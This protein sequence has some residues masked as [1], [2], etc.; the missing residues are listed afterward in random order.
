MKRGSRRKIHRR[1]RRIAFTAGRANTMY[2]GISCCPTLAGVL[3]IFPY[4]SYAYLTVS[5][6]RGV[7]DGS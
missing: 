5:T 7:V 6:Q 4:L 1:G 2:V 3:I